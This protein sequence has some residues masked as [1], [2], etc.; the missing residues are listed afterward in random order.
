MRWDDFRRRT[1]SRMTAVVVAAAVFQWA[2]AASA[3]EL[4]LYLA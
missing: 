1:M 2:K 3:L 4:S